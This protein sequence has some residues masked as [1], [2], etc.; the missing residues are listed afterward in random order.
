MILVLGTVRMPPENLARA[1]S[2]M[3]AMVA[4]SRA[5]DGCLEYGYA[6]DLLDPGL[7]RVTE[8]WTS[9]EALQAHFQTPHM[10]T[11]RAVWP[12]LGIGE[13]SLALYEA[14][15]PEPL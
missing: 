10:G 5:E 3:E 1:R 13:R 9:R 11:W 15:D 6:Q 14:G 7:I 2:A 8:M 4:A 12:S